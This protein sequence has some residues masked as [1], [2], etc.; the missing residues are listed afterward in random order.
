[1]TLPEEK[2]RQRVLYA[3]PDRWT[4]NAEFPP[5]ERARFRESLLGFA[6]EWLGDGFT[7]EDPEGFVEDT[8]EHRAAATAWRNRNARDPRAV[9]AAAFDALIAGALWDSPVL[10]RGDGATLRFHRG[11]RVIVDGEVLP[12]RA[13][14]WRLLVRDR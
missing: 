8:E 12:E 5:E 4:V 14:E 1:M 10:T 11:W 6:A 9:I 3:H 13:A 7:V 2:P